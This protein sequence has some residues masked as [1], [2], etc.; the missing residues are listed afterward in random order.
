VPAA[1]YKEVPGKTVRLT[2]GKGS[3]SC[4]V[5]SGSTWLIPNLNP[6]QRRRRQ[7]DARHDEA[8][9]DARAVARQ[10]RLRGHLERRKR[11]ELRGQGNLDHQ[12]QGQHGAT[13]AQAIKL[14]GIALTHI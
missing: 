1:E 13:A 7:A 11:N 6:Q 9:A 10:R 12:L 8:E 2:P 4:N 3:S 14:A 5:R